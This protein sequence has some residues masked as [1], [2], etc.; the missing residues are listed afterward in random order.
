M[1]ATVIVDAL[2]G[3]SGKGKVSAYLARKHGA[4]LA[5]RAGIGTNA[6]ASIWL[7]PD[8][9]VRA[10]QLPTAWMNPATKVAVGSGVLVDPEV[11]LHEVREF[12]LEERAFVDYR[13]AVI[14]PDHIERE[15]N[16]AHLSGAVGST[17]TGNGHAKS[18]FVLRRATQAKDIPALKPYVK[19]IAVEANEV[20]RNGSLIVQSSQGAMLSLALS[21][22]YPYTTSA[23]CT[24]A[25]AI[26][27]VGL[28]W[29]LV[30]DVVMI[31]KVMPTRVGNGALPHEMLADDV[32]A[33]NIAERGVVTGRLRR[34]ASQI[35][36]DLLKYSAMLNGPTKI[37][38]TFCD[39]YA[40]EIKEVHDAAK[41]P[42]KV[43]E[44]IAQVERV[45][46]APVVMV[47]NGKYLD[48]F[49][50]VPAE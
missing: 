3:D 7:P 6:G 13:C 44:L 47:D 38:L 50:E 10:R 9:M 25:A 37:I 30:T 16:D 15:K 14:T 40:P 34:K 29:R 27:A 45:A 20:A 21:P 22:D 35:D 32:T 4:D 24:A 1:T 41:I 46:D 23:N 43:R 39:H 48:D 5:V 26:D 8:T 12:G 19:D 28:N 36:F 17:L 42:Q 31:V 33:L 18:D 2:W 49:I 11:F